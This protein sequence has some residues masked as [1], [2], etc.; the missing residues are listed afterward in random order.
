M[1]DDPDN[2]IRECAL[3]GRADL[4]VTGDSELL[5]LRGHGGVRIVSLRDYLAS[6]AADSSD[7]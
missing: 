6:A 1:S 4:I 2:R 5:D 7:Q 3:A